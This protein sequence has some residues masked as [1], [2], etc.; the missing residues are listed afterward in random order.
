[1]GLKRRVMK[2][3]ERK[4]NKRKER[5][6]KGRKEKKRKKRKGKERKAKEAKKLKKGKENK[7]NFNRAFWSLL[8]F[9]VMIEVKF[10]LNT[11]K[12]NSC[13]KCS[14]IFVDFAKLG[15]NKCYYTF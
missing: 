10:L 8:H 3:K 4:E 15:F 12:N 13:V 11:K 7:Y 9:E 6:E 1:M 5:K 2:G 14:Q